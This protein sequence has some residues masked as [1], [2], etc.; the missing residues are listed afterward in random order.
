MKTSITPITKTLPDSERWLSWIVHT[1][2]LV[3]FASDADGVIMLWNPACERMF[4]WRAE[5]VIGRPTPV[6]PEA[7]RAQ[8]ELFRRRALDGESMMDVEVVR[9]RRDGSLI[10]LSFSNAPIYDPHGKAV[11]VLFIAVDITERKRVEEALRVANDSLRAIIQ[12][13]PLAIY[14]YDRD[15]CVTLW[16]PAAER[17]FGWSEKEALGRLPPFVPEEKLAEFDAIRKQ[18]LSGGVVQDLELTR[19]R[20]DG[21]RVFISTNGAP[22]YD[23]TGQPIGHMSITIDNTERKRVE[24]TML[25]TQERLKLA[26]DGSSLIL[27]DLDLEART[28]FL[29][30][31]LFPEPGTESVGAVM[32]FDE[33]MT[34]LHAEDVATIRDAFVSALKGD[35]PD[36]LVQHRYRTDAGE[37]KWTESSGKVAARGPNGRARRMIGTV[38]DISERKAAEEVLRANEER[39]RLIAENVTDLIAVVDAQGKRVYNS[40]SY[41]ALFGDAQ[42]LPGT[43]SFNEIHPDDRDSVQRVF[44][45][46][47]VTGVGHRTRFRFVLADGSTRFIES[48]GS[49]IRDAAGTVT[50]LVVVSRDITDRLSAEERIWHLANYDPLTNLPNRALLSERIEQELAYARNTRQLLAVLFI[51]LDNFKRVNDSLGHH[52]GDELLR[53]FAERLR[54]IL[55][56]HDLIARPGGDEFIVLLPG[57]SDGSQ[58]NNV[59]QKILE[60]SRLPFRIGAQEAHISASIGVSFF[61][62]DGADA[63][64]LLKHADT[65]MYFAKSAG[66]SAYKLF[67]A[68]ME[69]SVQQRVRLEKTLRAAIDRDEMLLHYQ[70]VL[71][72]ASGAVHGMEA[73]VRW[74]H[75]E[76]GLVMPN[77]FIQHAEDSGAIVEIGAWV[78]T[79]A[80]RQAGAWHAQ[81]YPKVSVAVNVSGRQLKDEGF[82][83]TVLSAL[84]EARLD[85]RYLELEIT[86]S[87]MLEHVSQTLETLDRLRGHGI[88]LAIDDFGTGYSSLSY[89]KR[90]NIDRIKIDRSF[91]HNITTN[92]NDAAIVKAIIAIARSMEIEVTAEGI[93]DRSQ[94]EHLLAYGCQWG[95]GYLFGRPMPVAEMERVFQER[96]APR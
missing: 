43:D 39:F 83:D 72:L 61:P 81:G 57:L 82:V 17:I 87:V 26:L 47:L 48:Q 33:L 76:L 92:R 29:S 46:T 37:W 59:C 41:R 93:E 32:P 90:F 14:A 89:L 42:L 94:A 15:G 31:Q 70:P 53:Q 73:L 28:I 7:Y 75:P 6:V 69:E 38:R 86:E 91:V 2:P 20:K 22:L 95:Q 71:N 58:V 11:G 13:A 27:W 36:Y 3:I 88:K 78:V 62:E 65:A 68:Q 8:A 60:V 66:K 5:E 45:D 24:Q 49:V 51:D 55:R 74:K 85:P 50:R 56:A 1:S 25:R 35:A 79:Q 64:D 34:R 63:D 19:Q 18:V 67:T 44:Q 30:G 40:P 21:T 10:Q 16:N 84:R 12:Y 23:A 80:C 96:G 77:E 54:S 4:G 52:A 9:Q